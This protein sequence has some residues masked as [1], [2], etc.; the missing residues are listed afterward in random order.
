MYESIDEKTTSILNESIEDPMTRAKGF[1]QGPADSGMPP[2]GGGLGRGL[3]QARVN[4]KKCLED[5]YQEVIDAITDEHD[6][7]GEG[8]MAD[9]TMGMAAE[10]TAQEINAIIKSFYEDIGALGHS[11]HG[12]F[13][14]AKEEITKYNR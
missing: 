14:R 8:N 3:G 10:D 13:Y 1:Q 9:E 4:L 7:H 6:P 11:R 5:L 2:M 12:D